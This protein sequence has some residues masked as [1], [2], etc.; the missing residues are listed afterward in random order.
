[1]GHWR[2]QT[3]LSS[4]SGKH[5]ALDVRDLCGQPCEYS[6]VLSIFSVATGGLG[7]PVQRCL[8]SD[9]PQ[10]QPGHSQTHALS[11]QAV[12]NIRPVQPSHYAAHSA[13]HRAAKAILPGSPASVL[14]QGG[15]YAELH[16]LPRHH[17]Q[18]ADLEPATLLF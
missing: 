7:T 5:V 8:V 6:A 3:R 13:Q 1:M 18:A 10:K 15:V 12:D 4:P 2:S 9:C 17:A 16:A 14:E 11:V